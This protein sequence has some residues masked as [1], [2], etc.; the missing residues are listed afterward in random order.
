MIYVATDVLLLRPML[1]M[2]H[3]LAHLRTDAAG[4]P[5]DVAHGG[6]DPD[7]GT[8]RLSVRGRDEIAEVARAVNAML[9]RLADSAAEQERLTIAVGEQE[10][11]ARTAL[12]EMGE[13]F[14]AFDHAGRCQVCNP[15]AARM[16]KRSPEQL[17]GRHITKQ[18]Y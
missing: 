10:E 16:L 17:R 9:D 3:E 8:S 13:G 6:G 7:S 12:L 2:R 1:R 18:T 5:R 4:G 14:L 11:V 15:A